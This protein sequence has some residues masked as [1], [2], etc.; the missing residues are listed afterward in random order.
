MINAWPWNSVTDERYVLLKKNPELLSIYIGHTFTNQEL[1]A[2]VFCSQ[3]WEE[4][5]LYSS[6]P[7]IWTRREAMK[8]EEG[9]GKGLCQEC[10]VFD[11]R[12]CYIMIQIYVQVNREAWA[13]YCSHEDSSTWEEVIALFGSKEF[14]RISI[15][16]NFFM[17]SPFDSKGWILQNNYGL[18]SYNIISLIW[19]LAK[20]SDLLKNFLYVHDNYD[21][22]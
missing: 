12:M 2:T 10:G 4:K 16:M 1:E 19:F 3:N 21:M 14:Y 11:S 8:I 20:R 6:T 7:N 15:Q 9:G 13:E 22:H 18:L 5:Q 17:L